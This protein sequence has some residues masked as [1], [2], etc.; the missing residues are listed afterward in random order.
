MASYPLLNLSV[1]KIDYQFPKSD[2]LQLHQNP[3][4]LVFH[5]VRNDLVPLVRPARAAFAASAHASGSASRIRPRHPLCELVLTSEVDPGVLPRQQQLH[6][7]IEDAGDLQ[8]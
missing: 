4:A 6:T 7:H 2:S 1:R 8:G 5:G 3:V